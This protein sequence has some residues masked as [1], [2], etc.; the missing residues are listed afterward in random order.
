[1]AVKKLK[2]QEIASKIKATKVLVLGDVMLDL[3]IRGE[4]ERISPEAPVPILVEKSR[5]YSLGGAGNVAANI[6]TL[7]SKVTLLGV[8]GNDA[9]GRMIKKV[10][11]ESG[12]I[13]RFVSTP[14][15]PTTLKMRIV[16]GHHQLSR[17]DR[18]HID[19]VTREVEKKVSRLIE[20]IGDQD[21]VVV[22][23]YAKGFVTDSLVRAVKNRFGS[24]KIAANIKPMP[25]AQGG[26]LTFKGIDVRLFKGINAITMNANEGRFYSG[27]DTSTDKGAASAASLLAKKLNTSVVLTRGAHGLTAYNI[28]TRKTILIAN[29]ALHVFDV[30]GAGD[31]VVAT[32][33]LMLA[34]GVPLFN[35]AEIANHAGGIVVGRRGTAT[36]SPL[37]LKPFLD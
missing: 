31:T 29:R 23:D 10:C 17:V 24:K 8:V 12:I 1:M 3:Y 15:H 33:V 11:L 21:M 5:E 22:S 36:I 13:P 26:T 28:K 14:K 32:L 27:V 2:Y 37:D 16:S 34:I 19:S 7:G 25:V 6:A 9:E 4:V 35:A 20:D 18:E 30:T